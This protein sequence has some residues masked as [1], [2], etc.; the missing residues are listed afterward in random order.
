MRTA[1]KIVLRPDN[2][3]FTVYIPD[4]D[5]GTQGQ[6]MADAIFMARDAIGMLGISMEDAGAIIP[7]PDT[8]AYKPKDNEIITYVDIDFLEYRK[9][10]DNAK[11]KKTLTIR[12]WINRLAE[13]QNINFSQTLED[14]LLEKLNII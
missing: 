1:Y 12:S 7:A 14:A 6:D 3:K 8:V 13:A 11:I 2:K 5:S 4:F 9:S 10:H